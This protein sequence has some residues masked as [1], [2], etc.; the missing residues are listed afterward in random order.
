MWTIYSHAIELYMKTYLLA[1][2]LE[3]INTLRSRKFGHSLEELRRRCA[4]DQIKF[5]D[6]CLTWITQDLKNF[7]K[8]EWNQLKY[9]PN[10]PASKNKPKFR[11]MQT[12]PPLFGE[13]KML[14][15]LDLLESIVKPLVYIED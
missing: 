5:D 4:E 9:P 6:K 2:K 15:P 10:V 11:D 7:T 13:E 1:S 8:L 14:P 3:S 12:I